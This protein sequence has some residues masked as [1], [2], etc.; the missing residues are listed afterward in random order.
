[1]QQ[2]GYPKMAVKCPS[3]YFKKLDK[4]LILARA[5]YSQLSDHL[6]WLKS[7]NDYQNNMKTRLLD[8]FSLTLPENTFLKFSY[9]FPSLHSD[10]FVIHL[11]LLE[12][13]K[14]FAPFFC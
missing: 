10:Q 5:S 6:R 3:K 13:R 7:R 14:R 12:N 9:E 11:E 1:M 2:Y 8:E 4:I